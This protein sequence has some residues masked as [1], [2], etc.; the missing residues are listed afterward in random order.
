MSEYG[1]ARCVVHNSPA[2]AEHGYLCAG[3]FQQLNS[4]LRDLEDEAALLSAVP[5]M[6]QRQGSRGT[7]LASERSNARLDVIAM[8]DRRTITYQPRPHGPAC[9]DCWH[10]S[11]QLI[12]NWIDAYDSQAT[13]LASI[14]GTLHGWAQVVRDEREY[15][16]APVTVAGERNL[17]SRNLEHVASQPWVDEM[18]GDLRKLL[19]QLRAANGRRPER[20]YSR[21][22]VIT[23]GRP[24]SGQV[25]IHDELQPVWRRYVDRC[26]QTWEHAPGAALCDACGASWSTSAE[27]ARLKRMI[28]DAADEL[29]RPRADDGRPMLTADELVAHG[30]VSSISNVRVTAHRRGKVAVGSYYDPA[31][32]V[33][34]AAG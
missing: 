3:H 15:A 29:T 30:Y 21:C 2:K 31:W 12:R 25:W 19:D 26:A 34:Q 23:D 33:V 24:C 11:C 10:E 6:Q 1:T 18:F 22:P 28:D 9:P 20:P 4:M 13:D 16:T 17:L 27:K 7:G 5:S 32:F 14:L 8:N